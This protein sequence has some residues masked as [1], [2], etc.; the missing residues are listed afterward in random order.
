MKTLEELVAQIHLRIDYHQDLI[1]RL[2]SKHD[3]KDYESNA[4][5]CHCAVRNQLTELLDWM[6]RGDRTCAHCGHIK[7]MEAAE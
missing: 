1:D 5:N 2:E 6:T 3:R 4:L 7:P